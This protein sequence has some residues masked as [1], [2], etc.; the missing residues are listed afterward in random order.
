MSRFDLPK[1]AKL[2]DPVVPVQEAT[3]TT[4]TGLPAGAT[5]LP[6]EDS[7]VT[8]DV[9]P[10]EPSEPGYIDRL[11][12]LLQK[13]IERVQRGSKAYSAGEI[14]YPQFATYGFANAFGALFDVVGESAFS[15][16]STMTPDMAKDFLKENIAAGGT[17]IMDT[18]TAQAALEY[19]ESLTPTQQD[20]LSNAIDLGTGAIPSA[21]LGKP[22]INSAIESDKAKLSRWVLDDSPSARA[23]RLS[24][25]GLPKR[26]QNTL[27]YEDQLLNLVVSLGIKGNADP[28]KVISRLNREIG[29]LGND[30]T[31]SLKSVKTVVPKSSVQENVNVSVS[32][33]I[34]NNPEFADM[35]SLQRVVK[36]SQ[37]AFQTALKNYDG[38]ALGLLQLRKDFDNIIGKVFA[39]DLFQGENV[40]REIASV[41]RNALN[42]MAESMAP[43]ETIRA[44]L[45]R[46][47]LA[48]QARSN[49]S[50]NLAK[51]PHRNA[52]QKALNMVERHPFFAASA[53]QGGGMLANIPEPLVLG[54]T[55]A[56][57]AY[58]AAQPIVRRLAGETLNTL[59]VGRGMLTGMINEFRNQPEEVPQ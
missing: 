19:Y 18:E 34:K 20:A 17:A 51:R 53:V 3:E 37:Q 59:P 33:F 16:L 48:L 43:N 56:L 15:L 46:Q 6:F 35:K 22:L 57:G 29:V 41:Y 38:T 8:T 31:K 11:G 2:L 54:A 9:T 36:N 39:K 5:P 58:G 24:E 10:Q 52:A 21:K 55:G 12:S 32:Q 45:R 1:G 7:D 30:V 27:N 14:G 13:R 50:E 26:Q 4:T 42:D 28:K 44:K 47:H 49:I 40:S 23:R 25:G